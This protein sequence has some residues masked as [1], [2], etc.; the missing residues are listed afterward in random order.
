M[1]LQ[2]QHT[3]ESGLLRFRRI[4]LFDSGV[5][6]DS[7][8]LIIRAQR[9]FLG[10]SRPAKTSQSSNSQQV[11]KKRGPSKMPTIPD[12]ILKAAHRLAEEGFAHQEMLDELG[13]PGIDRTAEDMALHNATRP[14][15]KPFHTG[16]SRHRKADPD[17]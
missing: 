4:A 17:A 14:S 13:L 1:R 8:N 12:D 3:S 11:N 2:Y 7:Y 6:Q 15:S 9:N 10:N 5:L 16:M